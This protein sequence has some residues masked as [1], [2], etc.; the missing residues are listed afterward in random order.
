MLTPKLK[1]IKD[2][3]FRKA[4][5]QRTESERA[6]LKELEVLDALLSREPHTA[7]LRESVTKHNLITSGPK[8]PCPCCGR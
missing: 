4:E 5:Y 1:E 8:G 2:A 7:A 3:I 6:L